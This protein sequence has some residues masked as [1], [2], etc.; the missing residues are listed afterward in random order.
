MLGTKVLGGG[1]VKVC[2]VNKTTLHLELFAEVTGISYSAENLLLTNVPLKDL[3][4][5]FINNRV[6]PIS[7]MPTEDSVDCVF[8]GYAVLRDDKVYL[9]VRKNMAVGT[10]QYVSFSVDFNIVKP[11][12]IL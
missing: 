8:Q 9:I 7:L 1:A 3:D 11:S 2:Q 4:E 10:L 6:I 5:A 12:F